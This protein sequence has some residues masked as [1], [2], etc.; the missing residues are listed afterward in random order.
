M[1]VAISAILIAS[2]WLVTERNY[3]RFIP[4]HDQTYFH[5]E[6]RQHMQATFQGKDV[7]A[8]ERWYRWVAGVRMIA[9]EPLTGFGPNSFYLHYK[10]YT[11]RRFQTWV[12]N[13][14]EHSTVH[15]YFLL[16]ALEQGLIGLLLFLALLTGMFISLQRL[17]IQLQSNFYKTIT[18]TIACLLTIL[19][20]VNLM[21]DL[22][23]TDKVGA[24]FYTSLAAILLLKQQLQQEKNALT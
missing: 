7:S 15:N 10:P 2:A 1:M 14:P 12:S 5:T 6:F 20:V 18:L 4:E 11:L 22:I 16:L 9:G 23:E 19:V 8:A 13:N 21:S 17:Y 3:L 24:V